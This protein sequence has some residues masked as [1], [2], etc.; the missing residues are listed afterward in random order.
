MDVSILTG[1]GETRLNI[2]A[3]YLEDAPKHCGRWI[4]LHGD[5]CRA[6]YRCTCSP[7][8]LTSCDAKT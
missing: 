3:G 6:P 4:V 7:V 2:L 5:A 8:I 1:M